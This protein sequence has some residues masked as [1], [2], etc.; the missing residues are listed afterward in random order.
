MPKT[1]IREN[2]RALLALTQTLVK[3]P[4]LTWIAANNAVYAPGG[5]FVRLFPT[6][7]DRIAYGK[8][9]ESHQIEELIDSLPDPPTRPERKQFSGKFNVRLPKSLHAA[10]VSEADAEGVSLNQLVV[11]KLALHLQAK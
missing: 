6:K 7:A 8:T 4:G 11:A 2:A 3:S 9:C 10:L 1:N 5:P